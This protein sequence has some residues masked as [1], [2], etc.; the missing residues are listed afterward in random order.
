MFAGVLT[1]RMA[2]GARA[3]TALVLACPKP[4]VAIVD[5]DVPDAFATGFSAVPVRRSPKV[6]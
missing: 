1:A 3:P 4:W 2:P 6:V 5:S